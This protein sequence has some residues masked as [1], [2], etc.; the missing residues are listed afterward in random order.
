MTARF[1]GTWPETA[2]EHGHERGFRE[3]ASASVAE[4][5]DGRRPFIAD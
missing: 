1:R 4:S 5:L 3:R 2:C